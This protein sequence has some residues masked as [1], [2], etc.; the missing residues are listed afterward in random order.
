MK[1]QITFIL[2]IAILLG[3]C[4]KENPSENL[5]KNEMEKLADKYNLHKVE[6]SLAPGKTMMFSSVSELETYLMA[7]DATL[8]D[9]NFSGKTGGN[10]KIMMAD[11]GALTNDGMGMVNVEGHTIS[12]NLVTYTATIFSLYYASHQYPSSYKVQWQRQGG[13]MNVLSSEVFYSGFN[14]F[15]WSYTHDAWNNLISGSATT[16]NITTNG[17]YSEFYSV[18]GIFSYTRNWRLQIG[19]IYAGSISASISYTPIP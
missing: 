11:E 1:K 8:K 17:T 7:K 16:A 19:L 18:G 13:D 4:K 9:L 15:T 6:G 2:L 10:G 5:N 14:A 12:D 3:S